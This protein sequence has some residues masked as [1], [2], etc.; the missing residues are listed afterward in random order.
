M[1]P[2]ALSNEE[3]IALLQTDRATVA[4]AHSQLAFDKTPS[5]RLSDCL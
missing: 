3:K 2:L 5:I 4:S 1:K